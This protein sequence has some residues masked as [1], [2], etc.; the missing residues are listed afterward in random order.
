MCVAI[1]K[2]CNFDICLYCEFVRKSDHFDAEIQHNTQETIGKL[3]GVIAAHLMNKNN[4]RRYSY[5]RNLLYTIVFS[6]QLYLL[7]TR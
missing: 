2:K 6:Q 3:F 5:P 4:Q 7:A 1:I